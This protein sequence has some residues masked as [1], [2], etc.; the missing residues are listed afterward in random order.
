MSPGNRDHQSEVCPHCG[1]LG[2]LRRDVP[3]GHPDFG[4]LFPCRCKRTELQAIQLQGLQEASNI[5]LLSHMT[6]ESFIPGGVGLP[7]RLQQNL[8]T[9]YERALA[10]A[11]SPQGWIIFQGGYG[12][13]KTHLA[14]AIAN[15]RLYRAQPVLF[16]VVPDLLDYLRATFSPNSTVA[17]DERFD[18]VRTAPLLILDDLGSQSTTSWAQEKLYQV[19]NYRYSGRLPTVITTNQKQDELDERI[20]SRLMDATL[21]QICSIL[22]PDFRSSSDSEEDSSG[23]NRLDLHTDQRFEG[24]DLRRGELG[25]DKQ[26]VLREAARLAR[27]YAEDPEGWLVFTGD[28]G[29]GKTHLAAAIANYWKDRF[30]RVFFVTVPDLLDYLRSAFSPDSRTSLGKRFDMVR[31]VPLL[32]LDNLILESATPWA[33]E[34]LAQLLD[35]R[36]DS[37]LPTVITMRPRLE[38]TDSQ[39]T[40]RMFDAERCAV[41]HLDVPMYGGIRPKPT[42]RRTTRRH[43]PS[44]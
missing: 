3:V 32:V 33:R 11:R 23:L 43:S 16:V 20:R 30:H 8:R 13:G 41:F 34:K 40:A 5:G 18:T 36:Y 28:F 37:R 26:E 15:Y 44:S 42:R 9:N 24:F 6:F 1:G 29:A 2:Y 17:F 19:L 35:F 7:E 39:L 14:A 31:T 22:A 27:K 4:R 25:T 12:S 38:E 10:Y 21:S